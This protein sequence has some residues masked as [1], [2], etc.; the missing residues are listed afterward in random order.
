MKVNQAAFD[1]G[2]MAQRMA[3]GYLMHVAAIQIATDPRASA[4]SPAVK[5]GQLVPEGYVFRKDG[6]PHRFHFKHYLEKAASDPMMVDDL[7]RIWLEGALLRIGDALALPQNRY[8][9]HAP[10]LELLYHLRNGV[11]HGNVFKFTAPGRKRL[12]QYPAH[13]RLASI[14]GY[15]NDTEFEITP[16]LQG[17]PILFDFMGPGDVLDLLMSV[18]LYLIRLGNGD[19]LRP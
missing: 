4:L 10:E 2:Q 14:R 9:D 6:T 11:A 17:Q 16:N 5:P 7:A 18:S 3:E 13:N 8:F 19:P 12:A 1:V 15:N